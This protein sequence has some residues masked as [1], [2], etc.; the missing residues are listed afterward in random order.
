MSTTLTRQKLQ[1]IEE[2]RI[3]YT[4]RAAPN[5]MLALTPPDR[6]TA[7]LSFTDE[8]SAYEFA[9]LL[10]SHRSA[11]K[12]WPDL[13]SGRVH[14]HDNGSRN[15]KIIDILEWELDDLKK[16]CATRFINMILI[17]DFISDKNL[18]GHYL[19]LEAPTEDFARHLNFL[20][21]IQE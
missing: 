21:G 5:T 10:E 18:R 9:R 17:D 12:E 1:I 3:V 6:R 7:A 20:W 2:P 15:L 11:T 4:L 8:Y 13:S 14:F 19:M 16:I